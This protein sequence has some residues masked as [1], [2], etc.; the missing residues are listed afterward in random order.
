[1]RDINVIKMNYRNIKQQPKT[2]G[3][4]HLN[5]IIIASVAQ[6]ITITVKLDAKHF[7]MQVNAVA[8]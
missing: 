3:S 4:S 2:S 5:I 8:L 1:M 7:K 6:M